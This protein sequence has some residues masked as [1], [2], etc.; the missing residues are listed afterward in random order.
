MSKRK[1]I[2]LSILMAALMV[3]M[4]QP[5]TPSYAA[6]GSGTQTDPWVLEYGETMELSH[7][8]LP[9]DG[10]WRISRN[11]RNYL[12][13]S[14]GTV[15]NINA[16]NQDRDTQVIYEYGNQEQRYY[17]T[18]KAQV[19]DT[20]DVYYSSQGQQFGEKQT[21][22]NN[23]PMT[24]KSDTPKRNNYNFIGW[25]TTRNGA[26]S[27]YPGQTYDVSVLGAN[28]TIT[29]YAVW[30]QVSGNFTLSYESLTAKGDT[31]TYDG[32]LRK[33][34]G[35]AE[36]TPNAQGYLEI[37]TYSTG[38]IF[39]N[40]YY[41]YAKID[42]IIAE[43]T[44]VGT[45]STPIVAPLYYHNGSR[46]VPVNNNY[47][48]VT[49]GI[50]K[51]DPLE[52]TV[53]T[54]SADK[55]P[56][57]TALNAGGKISYKVGQDEY[58]KNFD[59][60]SGDAWTTLDLIGTESIDIRTTGSQ[61][62]PGESDNTYEYVL[63]SNNYKIDAA[64]DVIGKLHVHS[65][66]FVN[67]TWD[68]NENDGYTKATAQYKCDIDGCIKTETRDATLTSVVMDPTCETDGKTTYTA[69]IAAADSPDAEAHTDSKDAEIVP[70]QGHAWGFER[71]AWTGSETAGY[72][73]A[74]AEYKCTRDN[75]GAEG[76][77]DAT[78]SEEVTEPTCEAGGKTTYKAE[79]DAT[80]SRDGIAHDESKEAKATEALGHDWKFIEFIWA[81]DE[82][83][84]FTGAD[85]KYECD[86]TGCG[87]DDKIVADLNE[88][89]T[90]PKCE[91]KGL[92]T[93]IASI[94][95]QKS[96]NGIAQGDKK[97]GKET[98]ATG[99]KWDAGKV[100]KEPTSYEEGVKTFTCTA[101]G[102]GATRTEAIAKLAPGADPKQKGADG[103]AVG[104]GASE[105]CA[106]IAITSATS[107]KE[108]SGSKFA[109]L[110]VKSAKQ[111]NTSV[112]LTW[113][114]SGSAVKYV[115]Y[116]NR[117]NAKGKKYKFVN[118]GT[119]SGSSYTVKKIANS[120]VKKG[121]YYRFI[122]VAL[123]A[124]NEVVSTSKMIH[125][126]TKGG[127]KGNYSSVTVEA[128]VGKKYKKVSKVSIKNGKALKLKVKPNPASKKHKI[129]K[130]VGMR[131][132]TSDAAIATISGGKIKAKGVGSCTV[133]VYAQ[134][135][136]SKAIKVTVK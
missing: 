12:S 100:T 41:A 104:P 97:E 127:K 108:L 50:L 125:V 74:K 65:W 25:S 52:I 54:D 121:T 81:G 94:S 75:C 118:L 119:V 84:G 73:E 34:S 112:K 21:V 102:C 19:A 126:T 31:L 30:G 72:N 93:Y 113:V 71:F 14:N 63:T 8:D 5:V 46:Y 99:H 77:E 103:T 136:V 110:K 42:G 98:P 9:D 91:E 96:L 80:A 56:D 85:G 4:F 16:T 10:A 109:P 29:F 82:T 47:I 88:V 39:S 128:K 7:G 66:K 106:D 78:L 53:E 132:E 129:S 20:V 33:V 67:F 114:K 76:T 60:G 59:Y 92:T 131:Y 11:S 58:D 124:N 49:A 57:G 111:G 27:V 18:A 90:P 95:E 107:E 134:N 117:C 115:V 3:V 86:R 70:A 69:E 133:Y 87:K 26:A 32:T 40:D 135:G 36:G 45:Y 123:D 83:S 44:N 55:T 43:G 6:G 68:G 61:T 13:I 116:G 101:P 38:G 28:P 89:V 62:D 79:I 15:E 64:K 105:A 2:V 48:P 120:K 130:H 22:N 17:I 23:A 37:G 1:A 24:V 122:I 35:V 51:I